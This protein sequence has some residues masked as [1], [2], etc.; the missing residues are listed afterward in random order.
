[1]TYTPVTMPADDI[2]VKHD[3]AY[4]YAGV[5]GGKAR[6]CVAL[7]RKANNTLGESGL[8]M[9]GA[10]HSPAVP[11]VARVGEAFGLPVRIHVPARQTRTPEV[12]DATKHG[13]VIIGHRPGYNSVIIARARVDAVARPGWVHIPFGMECREAVDLTAY[14]AGNLP[15]CRRVV[16]PVGSGMTLAG[17]LWGTRQ[18]G[19]PILGVMVGADPSKR[20]DAWAPRGWR[21]RVTLVDA[22]SP[23]N[24]AADATNWW[25]KPLDAHYEAKAAPYVT[26][27]DCFWV[28][29]LRIT[30]A[31][32]G[33]SG[34]VGSIPTVR[35]NDPNTPPL[36][37]AV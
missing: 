24:Q 17:I 4:E 13:A 11:I 27:G 31:S 30:Q 1:M 34:G 22:G 16:V 37:A 6:T 28:V 29:G 12:V 8:V 14:Q 7:A 23:Y 20:L 33:Q 32:P 18:Q 2:W 19:L 10:A 35:S 21:D 25:G 3:D 15:A 36:G 5:V 9:V 26:A